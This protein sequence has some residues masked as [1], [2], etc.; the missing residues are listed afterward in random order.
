MILSGVLTAD[1]FSKQIILEKVRFINIAHHI[2]TNHLNLIHD[3]HFKY[4]S[5]LKKC[6][7]DDIILQININGQT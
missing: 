7:I 4:N 3:H 2:L 6:Q 1:G 5:I